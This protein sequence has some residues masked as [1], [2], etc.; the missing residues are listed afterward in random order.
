[1]RLAFQGRAQEIIGNAMASPGGL[2]RGEQVESPGGG[3]VRLQLKDE[4]AHLT[5]FAR[6]GQ[7]LVQMDLEEEQSAQL[8]ALLRG[9]RS[10]RSG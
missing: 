6:G 8:R 4:G 9:E 10:P 7:P 5:L 1:M 3:S 2:L